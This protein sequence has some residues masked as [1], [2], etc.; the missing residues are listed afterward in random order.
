MR[1]FERPSPL[2]SVKSALSPG[3]KWQGSSN[4]EENPEATTEGWRRV[5]KAVR[6]GRG[7]YYVYMY[8]EKTE[9]EERGKVPLL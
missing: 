7:H 6:K 1:I 2:P 5:T 4:L 9:E 8:F 3:C